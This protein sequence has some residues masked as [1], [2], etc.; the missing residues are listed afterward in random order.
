[1]HNYSDEELY[2]E[3]MVTHGSRRRKAF[4]FLYSRYSRPLTQYFYFAFHHDF[5]K[6]RD[7]FHDLFLKILE[8]PEKFDTSMKFK[9]WI[10]RVAANMCK[11]EFRKEEVVNRYKDHAKNNLA[12]NIE[13]NLQEIKLNEGLRI[14]GP[15]Q[16][17]LIVLRFKINLSIK[18]MAEIFECPEGTVKSRLFFAIKELSEYYKN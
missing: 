13:L 5:E 16:R 6:A 9:T 11:N 18:E 17:S 7:F 8:T 1:M 14:L 4:D 3:F 10:F 2:K 12:D 15:R